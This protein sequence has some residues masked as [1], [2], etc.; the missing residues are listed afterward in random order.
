[1]GLFN[2]K[3]KSV[4]TEE[5]SFSRREMMAILKMAGAMAGA[6]GRAHPNE[7]KMMINEC[8]RFGIDAEES[9]K[10]LSQS[11]NMD[12]SEAMA[13]I[14]IM[15]DAQKRYVCAYLGSLMAIDGNI[16]DN[17]RTMWQ[18]VSTL[19]KLPTMTISDALEYMA[20]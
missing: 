2:G 4:G 3:K 7:V 13:T 11:T 17:E 19:C 18:L 10:L 5:L 20:N 12:G 1:M 16:D 8:L 6:D 9:S 15:T 14:A